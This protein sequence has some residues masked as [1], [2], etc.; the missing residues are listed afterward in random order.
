VRPRNLPIFDEVS[1]PRPFFGRV[2]AVRGLGAL[3][4]A[5]YHF[6][7]CCFHGNT[8]LQHNVWPTATPSQH[9]FAW[10]GLFFLP[11]HAFLMIFFVVSGLVLR[12]ALQYGP[13]RSAAATSKFL[14]ARLFRFYPL[15]AVVV[16]LTAATRS[17]GPQWTGPQ[18][19]ANL[20]LLDVSSNNHLWA[21]QVELC[22]AP[23][24]L[25][26]YFVER[27]YGPRILAAVAVVTSALAF[28]PRWAG[29]PPLSNNLF[30]FVIG[31]TVP[32]LGRDAIR[33]LSTRAATRWLMGA[34][35]AML[36]TAPTMGVYSRYSAV[37]EAYAAAIVVGILAYRPELPGL[38][39]LD[40]R[41]LRVLGA[42]AGS[43]YVLHMAAVPLLLA[44]AEGIVPAG[45]SARA[46]AVVGIVVIAAWLIA[47]APLMIVVSRLVEMPGITL[48]RR[49]IDRLGLERR[50]ESTQCSPPA[51]RG[52]A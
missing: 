27:R 30:A 31:M 25:A 18:W 39:W 28:A 4:V 52:A 8:L 45:W 49:L 20:L 33:G 26:L 35:A 19:L 44:A 11:A 2:D 24:I 16:L 37:T 1:E 51:L 3:A 36:A 29:W 38:R 43:Y 12:V 42:A 10:V 21:L 15:V 40:V 34:V 5:G 22:M 47:I 17:A 50:R 14:I 41:P 32:T 48:G 13:Q 23:I 7:G 9:F 6:S 46:P